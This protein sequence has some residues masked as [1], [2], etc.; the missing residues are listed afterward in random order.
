MPVLVFYRVW[1][2]LHPWRFPIAAALFASVLLVLAS[3]SFTALF[4][5][6]PGAGALVL[7]FAERRTLR[8]AMK[9]FPRTTVLFFLAIA[10][11]AWPVLFIGAGLSAAASTL[12]S[13]NVAP[14]LLLLTARL[15]RKAAAKASAALVA[16]IR[17]GKEGGS[18][19]GN[20]ASEGQPPQP[21]MPP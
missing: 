7:A 1:G 5:S 11:S 19:S 9:R 3:V 2:K 6:T 10:A 18:V 21:P 14:V 13:V 12:G 20:S 4:L 17:S 8:Q 16:A 15:S